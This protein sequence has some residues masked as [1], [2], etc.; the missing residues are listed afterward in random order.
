MP[1]GGHVSVEVKPFGRCL[2]LIFA[3]DD[4]RV[5]E[6][7]IFLGWHFEHSGEKIMWMDPS[8]VLP[9]LGGSAARHSGPDAAPAGIAGA[10]MAG[11][12][13]ACG[14]E[15]WDQPGRCPPP[16]PPLLTWAEYIYIDADGRRCAAQRRP[17]MMIV[18]IGVVV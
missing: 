9:L 7:Q 12:A 13:S 1:W 14:L 6:L 2:Q 8:D 15:A 3:K 4:V 5:L 11:G 18:P 10:S 16:P 17:S